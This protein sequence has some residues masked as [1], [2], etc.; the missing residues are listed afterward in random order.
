[1]WAN[2]HKQFIHQNP[3]QSDGWDIIDG[4]YNMIMFTGEQLPD[5][6]LEDNLTQEED[7]D[8]SCDAL[9]DESYGSSS[10]SDS[11]SDMDWSFLI[12]FINIVLGNA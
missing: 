11:Y 5:K 7:N 6:L 3:C 10:D 4:I 9:N 12:N 2:A 1:M 8:H